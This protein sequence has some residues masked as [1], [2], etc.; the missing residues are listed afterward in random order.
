[1]WRYFGRRI[2]DFDAT[3]S[4]TTGSDPVEG[5]SQQHVGCI[6]VFGFVAGTRV[7]WGETLSLLLVLPLDDSLVSVDI[8]LTV[9]GARRRAERFADSSWRLVCWCMVLVR[10]NG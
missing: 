1:M 5:R 10:S 6:C 2:T 7:H 3:L 8:A 4:I 9:S